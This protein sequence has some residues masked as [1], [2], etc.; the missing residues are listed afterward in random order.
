MQ[1]LNI[2]QMEADTINKKYKSVR[3]SLNLDAACYNSSLCK[4]EE[5]NSDIADEVTR[6]EVS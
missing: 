4:L 6:L 2:M 3:V 5:N 1:R